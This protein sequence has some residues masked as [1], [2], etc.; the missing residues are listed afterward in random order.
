MLALANVTDDMTNL[1]RRKVEQLHRSDLMVRRCR[2]W[3]H[4]KSYHHLDLLIL[5]LIAPFE[6]LLLSFKDNRELARLH[7]VKFEVDRGE[8]T[9]FF[10]AT[11][12]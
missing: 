11:A 10:T 12:N 7:V 3:T 4:W 6:A 5:K 9:G 8:D 2:T 1:A